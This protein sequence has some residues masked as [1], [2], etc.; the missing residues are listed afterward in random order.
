VIITI[1]GW[2]VVWPVPVVLVV[3]GALVELVE[4]TVSVVAGAVV[5]VVAAVVV[6]VVRSIHGPGTH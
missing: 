4:T 3:T 2:V 5:V 1:N 6:V